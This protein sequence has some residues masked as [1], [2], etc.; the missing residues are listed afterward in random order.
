MLIGM[1][2]LAFLFIFLGVYPKVLYD[3]LPYPVAYVPFTVTRVFSITQLFI[4]SFLGFWLLRKLVKGHPGF[5]LDTDWPARILGAQLIRFCTGPLQVLGTALD[6]RTMQ[7][8]G[9]FINKIKDSK[10]EMHLTP[11][12]IGYGVLVSLILFSILVIAL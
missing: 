2:I 6:R 3:M 5:V 1:G 10:I 8:S 4:F 11:A 7:L 12:F 9:E